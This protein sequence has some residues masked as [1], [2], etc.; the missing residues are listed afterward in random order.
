MVWGGMVFT[1][2]GPMSS[3]TYFT[4]EYVGFFVPVLAHRGRCTLAPRAA[5]AFH[6][7]EPKSSPNRPYARRAF[8]TATFPV[9]EIAAS[10][11]GESGHRFTTDISIGSTAVS[12]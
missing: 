3:S 11:F 5:R 10:A 8:A 12:T 9:R 4:L 7:G 6:R 2:S 1:V